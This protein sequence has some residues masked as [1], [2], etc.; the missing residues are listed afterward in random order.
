MASSGS[1]PGKSGVGR[2][3]ECPVWDYFIFS[4]AGNYQ[5]P[6]SDDMCGKTL[7]QW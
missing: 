7:N 1:Q 4:D 6:L 2:P 5:V 3:R